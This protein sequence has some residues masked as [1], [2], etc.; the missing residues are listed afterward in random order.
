MPEASSA[1]TE[2]SSSRNDTATESS[3]R[4]LRNEL[5]SSAQ[6]NNMNLERLQR[7]QQL[8]M[9]RFEQEEI[10]TT[11]QNLREALNAAAEN[12]S[13]CLVRLQKLRER[14]QRQTT[15]LF[16]HSNNCNSRLRLLRNALNDEIGAL[17]NME[18]QFTNTSSRIERLRDE[19]TICGILRNRHTTNDAPLNLNETEWRSDEPLPSTSSGLMESASYS[20]PSSG[21]SSDLIPEF[22]LFP[23]D[24]SLGGSNARR[25]EEH[26][27]VTQ[28]NADSG[29]HASTS[30]DNRNQNVGRAVRRRFDAAGTEDEPPR[31]RKRKLGPP[32]LSSIGTIF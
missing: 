23:E 26:G 1:N 14:L 16:E 28:S 8:L 3:I 22:G 27:A 31:R 20:A 24:L 30:R 9:H 32:L 2:E 18:L 17:N 19:F 13:L 10:G 5:N 25:N 15:T 7:C 12:N 21:A 29:G 6:A 4:R 11:L